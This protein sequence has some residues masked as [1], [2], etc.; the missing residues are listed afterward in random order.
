MQRQ[1]LV[2]RLAEAGIDFKWEI[3][4]RSIFGKPDADPVDLVMDEQDTESDDDDDFDME[5]DFDY[6][7][8]KFSRAGRPRKRKLESWQTCAR[9]EIETQRLLRSSGSEIIESGC[10]SV[11]SSSYSRMVLR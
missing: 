3:T 9:G 4:R 5:D 7:I 8:W 11:N 6:V 2:N 10:H 1:V